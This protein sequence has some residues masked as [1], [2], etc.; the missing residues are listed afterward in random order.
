MK[1]ICLFLIIFLLNGCGTLKTWVASSKKYDKEAA[2]TIAPFYK[3]DYAHDIA[4]RFGLMALFS[5]L[6]YMRHLGSDR[7]GIDECSE[8][9]AYAGNG[10][11]PP[12]L[13]GT[14]DGSTWSRW[15][16]ASLNEV[17]SC[18]SQDGL[19]YDTFVFTGQNGIVKEA[20]IAFRG[21]ENRSSEILKDW[22]SNFAAFFGF[23]PEQ[24]ELARKLIPDLIEALKKANPEVKIYSTGHSLG[25]GL[26]LQTGYLSRDIISVTTFNTSPVTNWTHLRLEK[27]VDNEFPIIFR[28]Y[29]GGEVLEKVR[30]ITTNVTDTQYG[31]H[32]VGV[33]FE[34]RSD[35]TGHS[36]EIMT[37]AMAK[38]IAS[39]GKDGVAANHGY[40]PNY[41][42][43]ELL[44]EGQLCYAIEPSQSIE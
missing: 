20:V 37:C 21:T 13:P 23:E 26:A 41:V 4:N 38:L 3:D 33:Q 11:I 15:R 10:K 29:H 8:E 31:R 24:Y 6:V 36:M 28:V 2:Q 35:F 25:G 18:F 40:E 39:R 32:D 43:N 27:L 44:K 16:S 9:A 19:F 5:E 12:K 1:Y 30:F 7:N 22:T 42:I 14:T 17:R 34:P